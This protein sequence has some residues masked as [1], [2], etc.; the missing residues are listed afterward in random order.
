MIVKPNSNKK[1]ILDDVKLKEEISKNDSIAIMLEQSDGTYKES[2]ESTFPTNMMFNSEK[3]GCIDSKG[4]KL[5]NSITYSN[6][7][8][9]VETNSTIYCYVYFDRKENGD[10]TLSETSGTVGKG[11]TS[12]FTVTN[13]LSG[14]ALSAISGNNGI[15]TVSISGNTITITGVNEGSTTITITS[16]ETSNYFASSVTYNVTV[17]AMVK[18]TIS[19]PFTTTNALAYITI[20]GVNYSAAQTIEVPVGT[21]IYCYIMVDDFDDDGNPI[22]LSYYG[23]SI[24]GT[25]LKVENY[26]YTVNSDVF[27]QLNEGRYGGK[28]NIIEIRNNPATITVIDGN[29][30]KTGGYEWLTFTD[31]NGTQHNLSSGDTGTFEVAAG[32]VINCS[33]SYTGSYGGMYVYIKLNGTKVNNSYYSYTV[34]GDATIELAAN[35]GLECGRIDIYETNS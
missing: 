11:K 23:I 33:V 22:D 5:E 4:N 30:D 28:L 25:S 12:T 16:A 6:G 34:T 10:L 21:N 8:V 7:I 20:D 9:N 26:N 24:N 18:V 1:V 15:A 13:N 27:I 31:I 29:P 3:S 17:N 2:N 14:G 19:S 35:S 32:T